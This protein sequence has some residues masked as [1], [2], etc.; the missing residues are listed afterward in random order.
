MNDLGHESI[1]KG[2]TNSTAMQE[3][4]EIMNL[5]GSLISCIKKLFPI[6][7]WRG[8]DQGMIAY[9]L[10]RASSFSI[11]ESGGKNDPN[12]FNLSALAGDAPLERSGAS[13]EQTVLDTFGG[14]SGA[15]SC[16]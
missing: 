2:K 7:R 14:A 12:S 1:K 5:R 6:Y 16:F 13:C 10:R 11:M 8:T 15:S 9:P 3:I 4:Q